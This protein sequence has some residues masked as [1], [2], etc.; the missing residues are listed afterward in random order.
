MSRVPI[1]GRKQI[2][3]GGTVVESFLMDIR[4]FCGKPDTREWCAEINTKKN[5][6]T[7]WGNTPEEAAAK[8]LAWEIAKMEAALVELKQLQQSLGGK[9]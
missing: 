6:C 8:A 3:L 7:G 1:Y 5:C 9:P 2:D 4:G